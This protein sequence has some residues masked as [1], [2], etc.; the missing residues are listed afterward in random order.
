MSSRLLNR[1]TMLDLLYNNPS[2]KY[3][4][5]FVFPRIWPL[6]SPSGPSPSESEC[7]SNELVSAL[8]AACTGRVARVSASRNPTHR[9]GSRALRARSAGARLRPAGVRL[10]QEGK[11]A[12]ASPPSGAH[13]RNRV[14]ASQALRTKESLPQLCPGSA[15]RRSVAGDMCM[16]RSRLTGQS[17]VRHILRSAGL[18]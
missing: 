5:P 17:C 11:T 9:Q 15:R 7:R 4:R 2:G 13:T 12:R 3:D 8:P 18:G 1:D 14:L 6:A 16:R 10:R